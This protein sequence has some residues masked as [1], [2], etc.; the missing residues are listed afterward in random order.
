MKITLPEFEKARVLVVGAGGL[1]CPTLLYLA[2]AGI[3]TLGVIDFDRVDIGNLQ[4][5]ILFSTRDQGRSKALA[6]KER[7]EA[8][9]PDISVVAHNA[10]LNEKNA[11]SLFPDYDIIVDGTD[12]F[13]TKYLLNDA[14]VKFG[15]PLVHGTIQAFEGRVSVFAHANGPCYRCLYPRSPEAR[16]MNC[17][18][19][20]VIGALPGIV[21]SLQAMEAIK[22][23]VGHDS[24]QPLSGRLWM[25]DSRTMETRTLAIPRRAGCPVCSR[26]AR[27]IFLSHDLPICAAAVRA[28]GC[29]DAVPENAVFVDVRER[30]EW[31][32]GHIEGAEHLPLSMLQGNPGLFKPPEKGRVCILYCRSGV[33]SRK[34][35]EIIL[36]DKNLELYDLTGGYD[37]WRTAG[38]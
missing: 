12:N 21:G 4:R 17:S 33:R 9:N 11:P 23:V 19:N 5:Q 8:L 36:R 7:L 35:A 37:A 10:V 32:E 24:F 13:P 29:A 16:I 28:I 26:S 6:A 31:N 14:A 27:D 30:E 3:G 22:L 2:G 38:R 34:A 18:Q 15:K 1:G 20:G 25:I